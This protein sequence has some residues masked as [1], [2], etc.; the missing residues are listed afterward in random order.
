MDLVWAQ[1][2]QAQA[3]KETILRETPAARGHAIE[4][5]L[6]AED[7]AQGFVP[8]PGRVDFLKWPSGPGI[9]VDSGIE[10]GQTIGTSF[11]S[12][13][14]KLIVSAPTREHAVARMQFALDE[15]VILGMGTNQSYLKAMSLHPRVIEGRVHTGFLGKEFGNFA[16]EIAESALSRSFRGEKSGN[17]ALGCRNCRKRVRVRRNSPLPGSRTAAAHEGC[18]RHLQDFRKE[19]SRCRTADAGWKFE[20]R[21]GGWVI[22]TDSSGASNPV[23]GFGSARQIEFAVATGGVASTGFGE[24]LVKSHGAGAGGSQASIDADLTAQFPGKVRKILVQAGSRVAAGDPLVLVE[25]MKMEFA[26]KAPVSGKVTKIRVS[27]G[28][29]L[30]PGDR[31]LDFE[32]E[33][34]H[35]WQIAIAFQFLKSVPGTGF[36]TKTAR[37]RLCRR[38]ISFA[39]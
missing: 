6:Y 13:L 24:V 12:M 32:P 31:F 11:D 8:T 7:P 34:R 15:T 33:G 22:A 27:E 35:R 16:P 36:R 18:R 4:V 9:R 19:D 38:S 28:Q 14:A 37:F 20:T 17:H 23:R 21:P 30:S 29:Q 5:R 10:Q 26:V 2:A 1:L 39:G 3:P 25:A